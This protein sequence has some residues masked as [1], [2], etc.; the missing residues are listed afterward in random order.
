MATTRVN[1]DV[2]QYVRVTIADILDPSSLLLQ[3]H[4]DTVR[5][6]F[7][8]VKPAKSN[9]VFHELGGEHPP[10]TV[11]M[12]EI[13][14]WALAMTERCALTATE[15][16]LPI[17]ISKRNDMGVG[18]Y[19]KNKIDNMLDL[20]FLQSKAE[21]LTLA[22]NTA[23]N[24]RIVNLTPGHGLTTANSADHILEL[25]DGFFYQGRIISVTGDAVSVAP[26]ISGVF[27]TATTIVS[28]GNNNLCQDSATLAPIDGSVT[29]V[30]FA[31]KPTAGQSGDITR[32]T[33]AITSPNPGDLTTFGGGPALS[34]GITLRVKKP[35]GSF[36]NLFTYRDNFDIVI[37]GFDNEV[38]L[39]KQGNATNGFIG[40]VTFLGQE[41]HSVAVRLDG[42]LGEEL[43]I[44]IL[45]LM[46]NTPD[47]NIKVTALAEGAEIAGF[48]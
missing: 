44:V 12:T 41:A 24:D 10:F 47:G 13:P 9:S 6:A 3:S 23:I 40:R 39:P 42:D 43:Q 26:P 29:P 27:E 46:N 11:P 33:I 17:E 1:L 38:F 14:C 35:D 15:Q 28:T 37:H 45:E 5:I 22:A 21:G 18:T 36:K 8:T 16:R 30:I 25:T 32:M 48:N 34:V 7:S 4:R 31:V 19:D 2:T 20:Y